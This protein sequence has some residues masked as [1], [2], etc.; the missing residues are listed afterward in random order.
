MQIAESS[1]RA[2]TTNI[3]YPTAVEKK[4]E[5]FLTELALNRAVAAF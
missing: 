3:D 2:E 1:W 4:Q 5:Q